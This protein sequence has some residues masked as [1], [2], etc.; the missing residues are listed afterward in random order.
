MAVTPRRDQSQRR[1]LMKTNLPIGGQTKSTT[2]QHIRYEWYLV[3]QRTSPTIGNMME[4]TR[5]NQQ[6]DL[7]LFTPNLGK[8]WLSTVAVTNMGTKVR[9]FRA[10]S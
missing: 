8:W 5:I 10:F 6:A 4:A 2:L 9:A 1:V 7:E 3:Q